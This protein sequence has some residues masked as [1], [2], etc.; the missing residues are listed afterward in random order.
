VKM[1][2]DENDEKIIEVVKTALLQKVYR[3][4]CK[5]V[6]NINILKFIIYI[7]IHYFIQILLY[8]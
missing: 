6:Q 7:F 3:F 2:V 8:R 5:D 4:L 1:L